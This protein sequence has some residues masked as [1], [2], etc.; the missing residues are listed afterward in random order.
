VAETVGRVA[1]VRVNARAWIE[2]AI[3]RLQSNDVVLGVHVATNSGGGRIASLAALIGVCLSGVGAGTYCVATALLP[4]PKPPLRAEAPKRAKTPTSK[5]HRIHLPPHTRRVVVAATATPAPRRA[6]SPSPTQRNAS[7]RPTTRPS[8]QAQAGE[9][10]F[11][12][13]STSG[14]SRATTSR[15]AP[16][17]STSSAPTFETGGSREGGSGSGGEFSSPNGGEFSP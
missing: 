4:D 5:S 3:Q 1:G 7:P 6:T 16:A 12:S 14:S 2:A 17:G 15:G 9:F 8:D 11:E 13:G 10:Q